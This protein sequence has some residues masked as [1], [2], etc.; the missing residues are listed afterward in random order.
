VASPCVPLLKCR[1]VARKRG[2]RTIEL[3]KGIVKR[4]YCFPGSGEERRR[5][6]NPRPVTTRKKEGQVKKKQTGK[7]KKKRDASKSF[8]MKVREEKTGTKGLRF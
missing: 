5:D 6:S 7:L 8:R 4:R 1:Y 3:E 2:E